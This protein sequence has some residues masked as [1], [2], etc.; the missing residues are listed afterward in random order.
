MALGRSL[1]EAWV[2]GFNA[3]D[4][5]AVLAKYRPD[6]ELTSPVYA[7]FSGGSATARGIEALRDYFGFAFRRFPDLRF[8][9]LEVLEGAASVAVR[10]HTSVDD[11]ICVECMEYDEAG[12]VSRVICHYADR[13][14]P[15]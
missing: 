11:R 5:D 4:L 15:A 9:L 10:Y 3:H 12:R 7:R 13:A 2:D 1:A 14:R 6:V 8:T